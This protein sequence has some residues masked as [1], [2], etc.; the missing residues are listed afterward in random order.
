MLKNCENFI[1]CQF[2]VL[3]NRTEAPKN[4]FE[5]LGNNFEVLVC[6]NEMLGCC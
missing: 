5:A 2:E 4:C 1:E 6:K 3:G